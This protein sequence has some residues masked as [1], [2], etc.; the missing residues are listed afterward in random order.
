VLTDPVI[1]LVLL[2]FAGALA[3]LARLAWRE[4]RVDFLDRRH[5]GAEVDEAKDRLFDLVVPGLV[6][7]GFR[8]AADGGHTTIL[9]RRFFPA[10]TILLAVLLF[11]LGL[12]ALLARGRETITIA[13][14]G[15]ALEVHGYC[16]RPTA[17]WVLF[18]LED[19]AADRAHV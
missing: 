19:V 6:H 11:P 14:R 13:G 7:N 12:L 17:D 8:T 15:D 3:L 10:W 18:A 4:R 16:S 1:P 2:A 5:V 9:E